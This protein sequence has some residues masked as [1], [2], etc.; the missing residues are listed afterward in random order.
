[1]PRDLQL[2]VCGQA[3]YQLGHMSSFAMLARFFHVLVTI[4]QSKRR[5]QERRQEVHRRPHLLQV[6]VQ[7]LQHHLQLVHLA[8]QVQGR[9]LTGETRDR[10]SAEAC[11]PLEKG[12][13][14]QRVETWGT[15]PSG[16]WGIRTLLKAQGL[17]GTDEQ[18]CG[19]PDSPFPPLDS[20]YLWM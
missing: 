19:K 13:S 12:S 20:G 10:V 17:Q 8:C 11:Q 1:M 16:L 15:G 14:S 7:L 3:L 18:L 2:D 6:C 5:G 9:L 4:F